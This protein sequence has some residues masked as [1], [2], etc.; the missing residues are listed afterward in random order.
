ME[1][2]EIASEGVRSHRATTGRY[3][4]FAA[5]CVSAA[6][7]ATLLWCVAW[8]FL[9]DG[10]FQ[11]NAALHL[12]LPTLILTII[13]LLIYREHRK[14]WRTTRRLQDILEGCRAGERPIGEL[15]EMVGG[16]AG[17]AA[18][19]AGVLHDLR[20]ERRKTA[21]LEAELRQRVANRT[22]A[23]ERKMS[24]LRAQAT[25]DVL[26]GLYNRRMLEECLPKMIQDCRACGGELSVLAIDV[27]NFKPLNDTLGHAV[28]D[29]FLRSI[30]QILRSGVR[31]CDAAIR[32]G[33]DEFIILLPGC[34]LSA[35]R[36]L[37]ER[38]A[39]MVESLAKTIK[40]PRPPGLSVGTA[41]LAHVA[42]PNASHEAIIPALLEAADKQLYI[43]KATRK[44]R[45]AA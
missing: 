10:S 19:A 12:S 5:Q 7:A 20:Q 24:S 8:L 16:M 43:S 11:G 6:L 34:S 28:G 33:G 17:V 13:S 22:N 32:S 44:C 27:D 41:S 18:A 3:A 31:E 36:S 26:T 15:E 23:L 38:L 4:L 9:E 21:E 42:M 14:W 45:S 40:S 1:E 29:E 37:A 39:A 35:A 25:R 2:Q 30:A